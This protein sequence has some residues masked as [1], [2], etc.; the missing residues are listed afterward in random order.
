MSDKGYGIGGGNWTYDWGH[1]NLNEYDLSDNV[2]TGK[3]ACTYTRAGTE[4]G[5]SGYIDGYVFGG[6]QGYGSLK[7]TEKYSIADNSWTT[8]TDQPQNEGGASR[9]EP[10]SGN[11]YCSNWK[12][13]IAG[14]SWKGCPV[15]NGG[16]G[17]FSIG[18]VIYGCAYNNSFKY[19]PSED[20]KV[21][22]TTVPYNHQANCAGW[23]DG[24]NGF[25]SGGGSGEISRC[26][27]YSPSGNSWTQRADQGD[28][29]GDNG[30]FVIDG[31]G[32]SFCGY[33]YPNTSSNY[34]GRFDDGANSWT[35]KATYPQSWAGVVGFYPLAN[36]P[37]NA[38][39]GLSASAS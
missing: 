3:T 16:S 31:K 28:A 24:T 33:A 36:L 14:D 30:S 29:R 25:L 8:K 22:I 11:I 32:H 12:Y 1:T 19:N 38:P 37:P 10:I 9:P 35:S 39:T 7:K 18:G 6:S 34:N 27:R 5:A 21:A 23:G 4:T 20:T 15:V 26:D 17:A 13:D 2:W